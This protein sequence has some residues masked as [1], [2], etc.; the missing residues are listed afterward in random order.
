MLRTVVL[1]TLIVAGASAAAQAD[2]YRWVDEHGSVHY[3]DEW[4]PGSQLIK[5]TRPRSTSSSDTAGQHTALQNI[6]A[7]ADRASSQ[8]A[9][10]NSQRAVQEDVAKVRAQQCKE[11]KERYDKVVEARRI[12]KTAAPPAAADGKPAAGADAKPQ[13][14]DNR[15][16][17]SDSQADA[18]RLQVY[19]AM[20]EACGSAPK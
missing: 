14:G 7:A 6:S 16:M 13:T 11:A 20:V 4:V 15:E 10:E 12:Y 9:Q 19:N 8:L 5:T 17:L 18:Y 1:G 2:V 3:S